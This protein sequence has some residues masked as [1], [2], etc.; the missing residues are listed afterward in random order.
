MQAASTFSSSS[1]CD[2]KR[3]LYTWIY[4]RLIL[5]EQ[6]PVLATARC[7]ILLIRFPRN[8][9]IHTTHKPCFPM[10]DV[11]RGAI[12]RRGASCTHLRRSGYRFIKIQETPGLAEIRT[13]CCVSVHNPTPYRPSKW[14]LLLH[15]QTMLYLPDNYTT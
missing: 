3:P 5:Q 14:S 4:G 1:A 11:Y 15:S 12:H 6:K 13:L 7:C 2:L 10:R 9:L 8:R